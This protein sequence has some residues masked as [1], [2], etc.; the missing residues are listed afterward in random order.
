M[1]PIVSQF[2]HTYE[3]TSTNCSLYIIEL[4][5][6]FVLPRLSWAICTLALKIDP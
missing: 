4:K 1:T 6:M 5:P 3:V 2:S